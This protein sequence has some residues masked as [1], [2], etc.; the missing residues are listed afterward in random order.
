MVTIEVPEEMV[1]L[2]EPIVGHVVNFRQ[3]AWKG[4]QVDFAS[5]EREFMKYV[6][7]FET[8]CTLGIMLQSLDPRASRVEVRGRTYKRMT[9]ENMG[10]E[11]FAMRGATRVTRGL[12]RD[13]AVRNGPT[14]V[15]MDLRAGIVE[16]HLTPAAAKGIASLGQAMP[17]REAE[18]NCE[19]LGV[20]P[21]SRSEH[22]R[23]A[24]DVGERWGELRELHEDKLV[25]TLEMPPKTAALSVAV[26]RVSLPMA[27][28]RELTAADIEKGVKNPITVAFRMAFSAVITTYDGEGEPL[29]C[30]RYAHVPTHGA[31]EMEEALREDLAILLRRRPDLD[32]VSLADGA[33]EMQ[34]ILDRA[35]AGRVVK[36]ALIDFWHVLEH[37]G[38][39]A[40]ASGED[41]K[42]V[43]PRFRKALLEDDDAITGIEVELRTWALR[44]ASEET[45]NTMPDADKLPE[46]LH[47]AL[48]YVENNSKRMR[49]ASVHAAGLPIGSGTVEA[50]GKTIV[51]TRM[52]RAGA[53]WDESGA[54]PILALR[55]LSTS[56]GTRWA[57]ALDHVVASYTEHVRPLRARRQAKNGSR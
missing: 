19:R 21:F 12:Y 14:I 39:A 15:P 51:E 36:A 5:D 29:G 56:S 31:V 44:F 33:P 47:A 13:E 2:L 6:A 8:G 3:R 24:V 52:R 26:D 34:S 32:V 37:L 42:Q 4:E 35:T 22:F 30:I 9:N 40:R 57:E 38:K 11:Y 10:T 16:G 55:A 46:D 23:S 20:L 50:T 41:A 17:S 25:E 27:E 54:Q 18:L 28:P 7:A 48:T 53:R 1:P 43:T 49:Y 45:P